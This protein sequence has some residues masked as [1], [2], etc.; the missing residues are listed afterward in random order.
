LTPDT[1]SPSNGDL[2]VPHTGWL[3]ALG[4]AC[5]STLIAAITT[6]ACRTTDGSYTLE[7]GI[8]SPY[9]EFTDLHD[10][11]FSFE[12]A[13]AVPAIYFAPAI[14]AG[15]GWLFATRQNS[16]SAFKASIAV[17]TLLTIG[18]LILMAFAYVDPVL[19]P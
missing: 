19:A 1:S 4:F 12:S 3:A 14:V 9:C 8:P 18:Q 5:V 10:F 7:A 6:A 11:G 13:L 15:L 2:R 16:R 17:A